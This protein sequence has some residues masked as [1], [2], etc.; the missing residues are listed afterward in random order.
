MNIYLHCIHIYQQKY[1]NIFLM[2]SVLNILNLIQFFS[3]NYETSFNKVYSLT[4]SDKQ[5]D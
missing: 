1:M 3:Q 4:W 5:Y 2:S